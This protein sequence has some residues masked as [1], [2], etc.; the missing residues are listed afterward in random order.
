MT[1][2]NIS[3]RRSVRIV[4]V[5][6]LGSVAL[7]TALV[8]AACG[9]QS[10]SEYSDVPTIKPAAIVVPPASETTFIVDP[11]NSFDLR[12]L[13]LGL[14]AVASALRA[15]PVDLPESGAFE[16]RPGLKV[17]LRTISGESY[18]PESLK[19]SGEVSSIP[20]IDELKIDG[21][22]DE[23][24][25]SSINVEAQH[26]AAVAAVA[27]ARKELHRLADQVENLQLPRSGCSD[28]QGAI[29]AAA[30]SFR[31]DSRT[32]VVISDMDQHCQGNSSGSLAEVD[33]LIVLVCDDASACDARM[34][35]WEPHLSEARRV[36]FV[37][38]ENAAQAIHGFIAE[39][40]GS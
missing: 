22:D 15:F 40:Q 8:I 29:S 9:D 12:D 6:S 39:G 35:E 26:K 11:S 24:I 7:L 31:G 16:G 1:D 4:R 36:E 33:V 28:V 27:D 37:R 2:V 3:K 13:Q 21:T 34:R 19:V 32:L 18:R 25:Q 10:A 5:A 38:L 14:D 17:T 20:V 23:V 30:E